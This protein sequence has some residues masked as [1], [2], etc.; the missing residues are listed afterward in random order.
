MRLPRE[1]VD[2]HLVIQEKSL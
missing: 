2:R 1:E